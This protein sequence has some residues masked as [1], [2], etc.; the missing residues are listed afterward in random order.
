MLWAGLDFN[1]SVAVIQRLQRGVA[2]YPQG[3]RND[4]WKDSSEIPFR[5][6]PS[7]HLSADASLDEQWQWLKRVSPTYL[8]TSPSSIRG[9]AK[10]ARDDE[11][12]FD[13]ILTTGDIVD[14]D[15]R[16]LASAKFAAKIHDTYA[17]PETGCIAIQCPDTTTYHVPSEAIIVEVLDDQGRPCRDGEI[18]RV[19]ATP[20]FNL[21][22]PL[23]RYEIGDFAEAGGMCECMRSLPMLKRIAGRR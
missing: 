13:T 9:Y 1:Q 14:A 12:T 18:G 19:V 20:L 6:G 2:D 15:L 8:N 7:F 11:L 22:G 17:S 10:I 4:R 21:A 3:L 5:T 23:I 16:A